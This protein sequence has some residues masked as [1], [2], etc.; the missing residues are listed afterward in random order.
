MT[1]RQIKQIK[2]YKEFLIFVEDISEA[3][4]RRIPRKPLPSSV[5]EKEF[6]CPVCSHSVG[7]ERNARR[8][9]FAYCPNCGQAID[10]KDVWEE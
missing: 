5:E 4:D 3:F 1:S 8:V 2:N 10:R 7:W 9:L 6:I